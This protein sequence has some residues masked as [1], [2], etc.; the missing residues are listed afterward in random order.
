MNRVG[1][2]VHHETSFVESQMMAPWEW[3]SHILL[4]MI[5]NFS[6][7][8]DEYCFEAHL[9]YI[10]AHSAY[11][12]TY[13]T[14]I[15]FCYAILFC[16]AKTTAEPIN[17]WK[18]LISRNNMGC[19]GNIS[20]SKVVCVSWAHPPSLGLRDHFSLWSMLSTRDCSVDT[21]W[22]QTKSRPLYI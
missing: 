17:I 5:Y 9:I 20:K 2:F 22:K 19:H 3:W 6:I 14:E 12:Y 7:Y 21:D 13:S 4:T 16:W 1:I 11:L 15:I 10:A 8:P 18:Y